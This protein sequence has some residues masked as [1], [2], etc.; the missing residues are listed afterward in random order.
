MKKGRGQGPC[1]RHGPQQLKFRWP[2]YGYPQCILIIQTRV[3][4]ALG[5]FKMVNWISVIENYIHTEVIEV[6][7]RNLKKSLE[8]E[9]VGDLISIHTKFLDTVAKKCFLTQVLA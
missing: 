2:L 8:I 7:W 4:E 1:A 6:E 9:H 3:K 5:R